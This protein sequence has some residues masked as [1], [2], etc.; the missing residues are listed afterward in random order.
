M[1]INVLRADGAWWTAMVAACGALVLSLVK[2]V[3][4][5]E[6]AALAFLREVDVDLAAARGDALLLGLPSR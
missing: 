3:A 2:A 4:V 5:Y 1:S 6:A